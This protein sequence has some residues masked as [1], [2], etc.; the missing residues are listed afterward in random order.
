MSW[1]SFFQISVRCYYRFMSEGAE[2]LE[3]TTQLLPNAR[4]GAREAAAENGL[5]RQ[6]EL[7]QAAEQTLRELVDIVVGGGS[8]DD[9]CDMIAERVGCG[10]AVTAIEGRVL[11]MH[12]RNTDH[13]PLSALPCFDRSGR[14]LVE[15]EPARVT[16]RA[17]DTSP[18]SAHHWGSV[19]VEH[20]GKVLGCMVAFSLQPLTEHDFR[21]LE[22]AA[23][24][25]ALV[26]SRDRS[27][28]AIED[29]YRADFLYELLHGRVQHPEQVLARARTFGWDL[30]RPGCVVVAEIDSESVAGNAAENGLPPVSDKTPA[31]SADG[32]ADPQDVRTLQELFAQAWVR[33]VGPHDPH[34]AVIGAGD[35][36]IAVIAAAQAQAVEQR[37]AE[38]ASQVRGHGGGGRRPFSVGIS[39]PAGSITEIARA[40]AE[41]QKALE[42]GRQLAGGEGLKHFDTLGVYRLLLQVREQAELQSFAR[43]VLGP[44]ADDTAADS[45]L[46]RETLQTLLDHNLNVAETARAMFF[47]YNTLRYRVAK[48]ERLL[49]PFTTDPHLRLAVA[50]AL[51]I[52]KLPK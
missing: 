12:D 41:A 24:G 13:Q 34:A 21:L 29:K 45:A 3:Q 17:H 40:Y 18:P 8:L 20:S 52:V 11:A 39:R 5:D 4:T 46:L 42:V 10:A 22:Q 50:L 6:L 48:L 2:K 44:L 37:V 30:E 33:A 19:P 35:R 7:L 38:F 31:H 25:V 14:F 47:H 36:V 1:A 28:S 27:I 51:Q 16:R 49:G 26:M 32:S 9:V 23:A 15:S 43:E